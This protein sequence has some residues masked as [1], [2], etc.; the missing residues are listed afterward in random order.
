[1]TNTN[2]MKRSSLVTLAVL[3]TGGV[4]LG[5]GCS[6][7]V[8]PLGRDGVL[9]GAPISRVQRL[10]KRVQQSRNADALKTSASTAHLT[11]YGGPVISNVKVF[12]IFWGG[13]GAVTTS[14]QL[15]GFYTG[16]TNSPYFDWLS[17]YDTPSQNIG[18][19]AFIGSYSY[20]GAP[21]GT[22]DDT[23]IQAQLV[24]LI[25][26]GSVPAEDGN[27]LY[28]IHFAPGISITQGGQQSCV[29]FCAYHGTTT[30]GSQDVYYGVIPDQ[31]GSC[32]GGC[33]SDPVAF[34]TSRACRRTS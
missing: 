20:T 28:M 6:N 12:T 24:N 19:G 31:G 29:Q 26:A 9:D 13:A 21:T 2:P 3:L 18:R 34:N 10:S 27:T 32:A 14:S 7:G 15:N 11:Y 33:G 16:V 23:Q 22:I 25:K 4:A 5:A 17:E 1:M 30:N 8:E